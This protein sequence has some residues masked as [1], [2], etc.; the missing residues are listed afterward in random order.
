M[1][2]G[3]QQRAAGL[4]AIELAQRFLTELDARRNG[5]H[6][7]VS[8][9]GA[10]AQ[11][12]PDGRHAFAWRDAMDTVVRWRQIGEPNDQV[13]WVDRLT[14]EEFKNG[15]GSHTPMFSG[16]TKCV[17]YY[18]NCARALRLFASI[19]QKQGYVVNAEN[20]QIH[21]S[22]KKLKEVAEVRSRLSGISLALFHL[23]PD[24]LICSVRQRHCGDHCWRPSATEEAQGS[25]RG[26]WLRGP[27]AIDLESCTCICVQ[28]CAPIAVCYEAV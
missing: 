23:G 18:M 11:D 22:E 19:I 5:S 6:T 25:K 17:R 3:R 28:S 15:F 27:S 8:S 10:S 26:E 7:W 24:I 14:P 1:N 20:Q 2:N 13:L 21:L 12:D 9:E 16:Q 4:G